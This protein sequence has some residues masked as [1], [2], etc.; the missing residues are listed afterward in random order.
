MNQAAA[1]AGRIHV[2]VGQATASAR[3]VER[4]AQQASLSAK[5]GAQTV[6]ATIVRMGVIK[7]RVSESAR[8]VQ[9][10]GARSQEIGSI[11]E[12]IQDIAS[13]TNL[14]AL[15]AAIEAARAGE[16]GKSF[17]VV[18]SEVRKLAESAARSAEDIN[19]LV[20]GILASVVAAV[21]GIKQDVTEVEIGVQQANAAGEALQRI[22][23]AIKQVNVEVG[24]T[25]SAAGAMEQS[26]RQLSQVISSVNAVVEDNSAAA[27]Q[28]AASAGEVK[29][30][31]ERIAAL[32]G[33]NRAAAEEVSASIHAIAAQTG[34]VSISAQG[35]AGMAAA[36][37]DLVDQFTL[38]EEQGNSPTQPS[39]MQPA[40]AAASSWS[41]L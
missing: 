4:E 26:A 3:A 40:I 36:L 23:S 31:I 37:Q 14:L 28:V 29:D 16:N 1:A 13:Q 9:E 33:K 21:D 18:A 20:K 17:S 8:Q 22:T 24:Q 30:S 32:S 7:S 6:E 15:N 12:A 35:M 5:D 10:M 2:A 39:T 38:L 27:E 41:A 19:R 11:V 34:Q 25:I